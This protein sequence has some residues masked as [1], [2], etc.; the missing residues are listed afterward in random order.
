VGETGEGVFEAV[1]SGF[2][3]IDLRRLLHVVFLG[4]IVAWG[5]VDG[6]LKFCPND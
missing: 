3:E 6:G 2:G 5:W 4:W 1:E